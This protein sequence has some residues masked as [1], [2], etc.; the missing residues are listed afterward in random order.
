MTVYISYV[1]HYEDKVRI[2]NNYSSGLEIRANLASSFHADVTSS[3]A[4]C[5]LRGIFVI[6]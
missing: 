6:H 1:V 4:A 3:I 5:L 2:K